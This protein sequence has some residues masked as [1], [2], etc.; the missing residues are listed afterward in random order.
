MRIVLV[1]MV[2]YGIPFYTLF[3]PSAIISSSSYK[4]VNFAMRIMISPTLF[5]PSRVPE[6]VRFPPSSEPVAVPV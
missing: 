2:I 6:A 4:G 5:S 1:R 3:R